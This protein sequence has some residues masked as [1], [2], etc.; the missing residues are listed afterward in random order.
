M[1]LLKEIFIF[2]ISDKN[3]F[4]SPYSVSSSLTMCTIGA[5][6]ETEKQL[7]EL[8]NY[9]ELT[10]EF[11][12]QQSLNIIDYLNTFK[13]DVTLN[14]A[15][16]LYPKQ[17]FPIRLSYAVALHSYYRSHINPIDFT[18]HTIAANLINEWIS[19][20]TGN[21]ITD[22]IKPD[23]IDDD[24][25]LILVNAIYFKGNW[26]YRFNKDETKNDTFYLE[27]G[28]NKTV[29][30]MHLSNGFFQFK[31]NPAN[32]NA[33]VCELPYVGRNISMTIILPNENVTLNE[34]ENQLDLNTIKTIFE[35]QT[36]RT[37]VDVYIP[38]FKFD[39][40]IE[41]RMKNL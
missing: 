7:R 4:F 35:T 3:I 1:L 33:L 26:F 29:E 37:K 41:V 6:N 8:L 13:G 9:T 40:A 19:A 28:Q 27:N 20:Q 32:L 10:N 36:R 34:I 16:R 14:I 23:L 15:N 31:R 2:R 17:G 5:R 38:K 24:I 12:N 25:A 18:N 21:K 11:I 22:L 39:Q 30:M